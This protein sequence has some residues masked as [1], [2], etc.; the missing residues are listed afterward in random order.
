VRHWLRG[1]SL[2]LPLVTV[3]RLGAQGVSPAQPPA[4]QLQRANALFTASDW[5]GTL[6]AYTA[7]AQAFPSH[8]LSRF[9]VGVSLMELRRFTEGAASLREGEKLGIAPAQAAFRLAQ[10]F[11]EAQQPDSAIA[12]LNRSIAARLPIGPAALESDRHL[13]SLKA[14]REWRSIVEAAD[15]I[16][17]PCMHDPRAREFDFWIGDWD[18]RATGQPPVGPASRNTVTLNDNGCVLTEHWTG[19]GGSEGQSFNLFDR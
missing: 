14:R 19:A 1:L 10:L 12:E 13:G 9:R 4:D 2:I 11:A 16:V 5:K 18:V 17:R 7:I 15:A 3:V 8:A 6:D